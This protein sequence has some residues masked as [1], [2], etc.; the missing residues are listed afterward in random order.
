MPHAGRWAGAVLAGCGPGGTA[1]GSRTASPG[2]SAAGSATPAQTPATSGTSATASA[3]AAAP[4]AAVAACTTSDLRVSLDGSASDSLSHAAG[5]ILT[6]TNSSRHT[7]ALDGYPGLRLLNS[8]HQVLHTVTR[9]GSTFYANDP[10]RRLVDLAP[11]QSAK[12]S[13]AWTQA[14]SSTISAS[15]LDV[16]PPDT[17]AHLTISFRQH[18]DS[19]DLDVTALARTMSFRV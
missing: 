17:T 13:L 12:A 1:T 5:V 16:T 14:G 4:S 15:Y 6:L 9:W 18:I 10:G 8:R 11:G 7:C 19:G 2:S 3:S